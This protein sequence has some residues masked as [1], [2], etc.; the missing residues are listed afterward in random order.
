M[1][2]GEMAQ[3]SRYTVAALPED[4]SWVPAPM[5]HSC[6]WL[7]LQGIQYLSDGAYTRV[8]YTHSD[9]HIHIDLKLIDYLRLSVIVTIAILCSSA[10]CS[11]R[12]HCF[13]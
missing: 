10:S 7:Q 2:D 1:G 8:S 3:W 4:L 6:L 5:A 12:A 9:T 13:L 11:S